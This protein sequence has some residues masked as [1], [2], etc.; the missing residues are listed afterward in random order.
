MNAACAQVLAALKDGK[1]RMRTF[2]Q[3]V[4]LASAL[5]IMLRALLTGLACAAGFRS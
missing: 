1:T 5:P 2:Q 4:L 3:C